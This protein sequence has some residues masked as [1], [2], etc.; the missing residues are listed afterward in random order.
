M[1]HT[2]HTGGEGDVTWQPARCG[3]CGYMTA[4]H[5]APRLRVELWAA[6]LAVLSQR[7]SNRV[8]RRGSGDGSFVGSAALDHDQPDRSQDDGTTDDDRPGDRLT[9]P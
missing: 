8:D 7:C 3:S 9:E 5:S 2:A 4:L 1:R 6:C